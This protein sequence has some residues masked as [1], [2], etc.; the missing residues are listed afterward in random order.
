MRLKIPV[1]SFF[2]SSGFS[3]LSAEKIQIIGP[4]DDEIRK[5]IMKPCVLFLQMKLF[6]KTALITFVIGIFPVSACAMYQAKT[7]PAFSSEAAGATGEN[8]ENSI[9]LLQVSEANDPAFLHEPMT[10]NGDLSDATDFPELEIDYFYDNPEAN[11]EAE[12]ILRPVAETGCAERRIRRFFPNREVSEERRFCFKPNIWEELE[13]LLGNAD[14][15]SHESDYKCEK[16]GEKRPTIELKVTQSEKSVTFGP[17]CVDEKSDLP[18]PLLDL[19]EKIKH[20][21]LPPH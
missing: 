16:P 18:S 9:S 8:E 15:F 4:G 17:I 1:G 10:E 13:D 11:L 2:S 3:L 7:A 14:V 5:F 12:V 20:L 19:L 6:L 21:T